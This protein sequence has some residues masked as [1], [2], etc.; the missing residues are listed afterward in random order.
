MSVGLSS[1][2]YDRLSIL[3]QVDGK[4]VAV[5]DPQTRSR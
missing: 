4:V 2:R 5:L 3:K 1:S